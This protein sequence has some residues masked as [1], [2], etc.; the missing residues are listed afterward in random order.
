MLLH[1]KL[2][3]LT[4]D[5]KLVMSALS[6]KSSANPLEQFLQRGKQAEGQAAVE[7]VLECLEAQ[8]VYV[9]GELLDLPNIKKV[10][11][12]FTNR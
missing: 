4:D 8:G 3:F 12:K 1:C 2:I 11:K 7:L 5:C 10:Y 6:E 9:F